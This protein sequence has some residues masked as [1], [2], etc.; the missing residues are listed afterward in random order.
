MAS[1]TLNQEHNGI[2]ISFDHKPGQ[3]VLTALKSAGY[4]WHHTKKVWYAKQTADR[5]T[6][7]ASLAELTDAPQQIPQKKDRQKELRAVYMDEIKK[8]W[9]SP[10]MIDYFN[11]DGG[12]IVELANGDI[13][14]I[15]KP[16]IE[17]SFCFGY[18]YC[19]VSTQEDSDNAYDAM[20]Y[21]DTHE[22]YFIHENMKSIEGYIETLKDDRMIA[23]KHLHYTGQEHGAKLKSI[24]FERAY[25][26]PDDG[27]MPS[28]YNGCHDCEIL[29]AAER[30]ALLAGYEEVKKAFKKRLDTYLKK[31]GLSKLHTW[32]YLRD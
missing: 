15:D 31:Y 9:S 14:S 29:T 26:L 12:Y 16:S 22:D 7:A 11:K 17:T 24:S 3:D 6:L 28:D 27:T 30:A 18:G 1:Y 21:A 32:T 10:K 5:L 2:E 25:N 19:G 8:C 4:R 20:H 23:Y 13:V